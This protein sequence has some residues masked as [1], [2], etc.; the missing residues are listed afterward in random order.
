MKH[1]CGA[2]CTRGHFNRRDF[3]RVGSL[4]FLGIG[5]APYLRLKAAAA[6]TASKAQACIL[7]WLDGGPSH[8]DTWDPK[9]NSGFK[10]ISTNVSGIQISELLPRV[11]K[12][13]DK[14]AIVRSLQTEENNHLQASHYAA[15]GHRPNPAMRFPSFSSIVTKEMGRRG[16][17]PPNVMVPG[18]PK[19][20][21]YDEYFQAH[22]L[23]AQ[24]NPMVLPDPQQKNFEVPDLSLPKSV[25]TAAVDDRLTFLKVVNRAYRQ[26][27]EA[28]EYANMDTFLDQAWKM[29]LSPSVRE[30]FNLEKESEKTKDAYGRTSFGQSALLARRLIEAGSRFVTA[31]GYRAQAWDTHSNNDEIHRNLGQSLDQ[32]LSA[33]LTDLDQRGLL[34]STIVIAMGEFGRSPHLNP[35]LGRDH[36]PDCW[37]VVLGGGGLRGGQVVGASDERGAYPIDQKIGLG[38]I[39]ATIYE[40]LGIDWNKEYMHPIGRPLKIANTLHDE[41]GTPIRQLF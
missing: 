11:A 34:A 13:M 28:A 10:P 36:W 21:I 15:T 17:T 29:I 12:H 35:L 37:S 41:T 5:L 16:E 39:F 22:F 19:G 31:G 14:L 6:G 40:A 9:P 1:S 23:G 18:M 8:I 4:S 3:L 2:T 7:L 38:D 27:V 32:T 25:S 30:A 33:L 24:Y 26:K 20:K